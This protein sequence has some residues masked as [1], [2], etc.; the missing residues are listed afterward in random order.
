MNS[1]GAAPG[2]T[3]AAK[4]QPSPESQARPGKPWATRATPV[5]KV[6][7]E[8]GTTVRSVLRRVS[9][10]ARAAL[11]A[12]RSRST[13]APSSSA[14][15][16]QAASTPSP[17]QEVSRPSATRSTPGSETSR[18]PGSPTRRRSGS[19]ID[20]QADPGR[21][22]HLPSRRHRGVPAAGR[23]PYRRVID[24]PLLTVACSA[25]SLRDGLRP[26]LTESV[27]IGGGPG[28][29]MMG[30]ETGLRCVRAGL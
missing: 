13:T 11:Q 16:A 27:R 23:R 24:S 2:P 28:V 6:R 12:S 4:G 14:P 9:V 30:R 22:V 7:P 20:R 15:R 18:S 21:D 8:S 29:H 17:C 3:R 5:S 25:P 19:P 26:P 1:E 10:T